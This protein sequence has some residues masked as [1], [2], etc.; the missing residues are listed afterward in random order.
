MIDLPIPQNTL[1]AVGGTGVHA[2]GPQDYVFAV[3]ELGVERL[4][5]VVGW[6]GGGHP[7]CPLPPI[8]CVN[9]W[10]MAAGS[11]FVSIDVLGVPTPVCRQ[12]DAATCGHTTTGTPFIFEEQV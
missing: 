10:A 8:H 1:D 12:G 4:L 3:D 9:A 7:T 2:H 5:V 11:L 6:Q